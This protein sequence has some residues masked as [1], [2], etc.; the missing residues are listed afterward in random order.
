[1]GKGEGTLPETLDHHDIEGAFAGEFNGRIEPIGRESGAGTD[2]KDL[3]AHVQEADLVSITNGGVREL[4][5]PCNPAISGKKR[6]STDFGACLID[7]T[8]AMNSAV[9]N[10][11]CGLSV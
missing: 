1:M 5:S 6:S 4:Q 3:P 7:P 8:L 10:T 11:F 2:A 9:L